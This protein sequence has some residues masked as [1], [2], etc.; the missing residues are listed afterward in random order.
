MCSK[1]A[2]GNLSGPDNF[3]PN[4]HVL[5]VSY[6]GPG[7]TTGTRVKI[8]SERFEQSKMV[9]YDYATD[10]MGTAVNYLEQKGFKII[11]KAEGKDCYYLI[12]TTFE[13]IK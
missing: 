10:T 2:V 1:A 6:V 8:T 11:G 4:F 13:P 3:I 7:N 12:S 9:S 5:K